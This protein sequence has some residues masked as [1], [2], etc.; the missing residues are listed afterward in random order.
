MTQCTPGPRGEA[1]GPSAGRSVAGETQE[2]WSGVSTVPERPPRPRPARRR[3]GL[4]RS[5]ASLRPHPPQPPQPSPAAPALCSSSPDRPFGKVLTASMSLRGPRN[6]VALI[7]P[8]AG[9]GGPREEPL[10]PRVDS[11]GRRLLPRK[12]AGNSR[13]GPAPGSDDCLLASLSASSAAGRSHTGLSYVF[14][15]PRPHLPSEFYSL[16]LPPWAFPKSLAFLP[17]LEDPV[18]FCHLCTLC[19]PG[20]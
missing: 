14:F 18:F 20:G 6:T 8:S 3:E 10:A 13:A 7:S 2:G 5:P 16:G 19:F 4:F 1:S 12:V 15:R 11:G 9:G 17:F